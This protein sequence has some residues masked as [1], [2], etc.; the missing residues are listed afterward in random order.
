MSVTLHELPPIITRAVRTG[1][2]IHTIGEPGIGKTRMAEQVAAAFQKSDPEFG[3]WCMYTPSMAPVDFVAMMPDKATGKLVPYHN[4]KLPNAHETPDK[5]GI[6]FLGERDSGDPATNKV[7]QKYINNEDMGGL[8]KPRGVIVLSDSNEVSHRSGAVQ[9]SLALLSR[10]RVIKVHV[11]AEVYLKHF[12]EIGLNPYLQAYFSLCKEHV[13]TFDAL[14][15]KR[16]YEPWSNPRSI[17]RLGIAMDDADAHHEVLGPDEIIGDVG[18]AV[19]QQLIAFLHAARELVSYDDIAKNPKKAKRPD[20]LSDVYAITAMLAHTVKP[21]DFPNVRTYIEGWGVE[22]QV[23][24]LRLLMS[25]KGD[26]K[27]PCTKTQAYTTWFAK[28]ELRGAVLV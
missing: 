8:L 1:A 7:L 19:G 26:H 28:P 3:L 11:D 15:A 22:I 2:N 14:I 5:R 13:S 16:G 6:I 25:S 17:E 10:S 21:E 24:F 9:Q 12:A 27:L 23:L 20:K 4:D 18:E